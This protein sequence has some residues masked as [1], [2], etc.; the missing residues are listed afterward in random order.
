MERWILVG[1]CEE[2]EGCESV[3]FEGKRGLVFC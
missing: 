2:L 3:S 1:S